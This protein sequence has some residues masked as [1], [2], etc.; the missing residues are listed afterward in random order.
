[1]IFV[2]KYQK[3]QPDLGGGT[4]TGLSGT[5]DLVAETGSFAYYVFGVVNGFYFPASTNGVPAG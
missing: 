3:D 1:M 4:E 5:G 2:I